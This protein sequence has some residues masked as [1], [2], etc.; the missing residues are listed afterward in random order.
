MV[1]SCERKSF[2]GPWKFEFYA[3]R[4]FLGVED[5]ELLMGGCEFPG[6][7]FKVLWGLG[8]LDEMARK[9]QNWS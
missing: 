7:I 6:K 8:I 5:L 3:P 4:I 9:L 2:G 1:D